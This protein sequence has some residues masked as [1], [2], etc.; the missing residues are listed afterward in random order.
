MFRNSKK[1][2][3]TKETNISLELVLDNNGQYIVDTGNGFFNHM[4]EQ[5]SKHSGISLTIKA[6]GDFHIDLHHTIEDI[7]ITMGQSF[8]EALGDKKGINR[9][10]FAIIPM[11]EVLIETAIDISGRSHLV[12]DV[13]LN[14]ERIGD[15]ETELIY[16]FFNA[17]VN[18]AK[19]TMH[20]IKRRGDNAHHVI[21]AIFKSFAIAIKEAIVINGDT[22]R[23]TKGSID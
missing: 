23:S 16:E 10:G 2:R 3:I 21:E 13:N 20:I 15:L 5:F 17:F 9:Y 4:L 12:Y 22:I 1:H 7:G 8:V 14:K 11:D 19:I 6:A 18:N